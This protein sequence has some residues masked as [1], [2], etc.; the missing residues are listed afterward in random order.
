MTFYEVRVT[1]A[2]VDY[3]RIEANSA[4]EAEQLIITGVTSGIMGDIE[5]NH[6]IKRSP[7]FDYAVQLSPEGEVI[8]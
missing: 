3:Y 2:H 8:L 5:L 1:Q 7:K 6:T 4:E